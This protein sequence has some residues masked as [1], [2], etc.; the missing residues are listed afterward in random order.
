MKGTRASKRNPGP[1]KLYSLS[2]V[3]WLCE[4][5]Y[6]FFP[7]SSG[8]GGD[9]LGG[10][11][12]KVCY[13]HFLGMWGADQAGWPGRL[14][15]QHFIWLLPFVLYTSG[16]DT[17]CQAAMRSKHSERR[18]QDQCQEA[19]STPVP[20]GGVKE[21]RVLSYQGNLGH[22]ISPPKTCF[23]WTERHVSSGNDR[24]D[25]TIKEWKLKAS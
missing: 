5:P 23:R 14:L 12:L 15:Y 8:L 21:E 9:R 18:S 7:V 20:H 24:F 3:P 19:S 16:G 4:V 2:R 25:G 13:L 10:F 17:E 11:E 1:I 6:C 22:R